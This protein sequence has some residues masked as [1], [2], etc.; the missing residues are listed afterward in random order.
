MTKFQDEREFQRF[1]GGNPAEYM[2]SLIY[3]C[4]IGKGR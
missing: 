2:I 4:V 3:G 1:I